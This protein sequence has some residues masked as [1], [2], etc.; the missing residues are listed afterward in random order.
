MKKSRSNGRGI[1]R[2]VYSPIHHGLYAAKNVVNAGLSTVGKVVNAGVGGVDRAG[3]AVTGH[4]N[5][6]I[7]NVFRGLSR[8]GGRRRRSTRRR[9]H[10]RR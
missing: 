10:R 7:S 5:S 3:M 8:K 2:R 4:A 6:A 1:F 9:T